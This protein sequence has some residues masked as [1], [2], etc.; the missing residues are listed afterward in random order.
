MDRLKQHSPLHFDYESSVV[1]ERR[2]IGYISTDFNNHA[3]AHLI[4]GLLARHDR[5]RYAVYGYSIGK[6]DN[7]NYRGHVERACDT[8]RD[9]QHQSIASIAEQIHQ[10][11]ID[12]LIDLNGYSAANRI[13]IFALRP[14]PVQMTY[15]GFPSTTGAAFFDYIITDSVVTPADQQAYFDERFLSL[16]HSYQVNSPRPASHDKPSRQASGLPE[17]GA[18]FCCFN[19]HYKIEPTIFDL[20]TRILKRV[21][22]SVLWLL[23]GPADTENNLRLEAERRGLDPARLIFAERLPVADHLA[24]YG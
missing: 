9:V 19:N 13:E 2:R 4:H 8:F 12:I 23:S 10:D 3:T 24:R 15:L 14:A 22:N 5:Y 1:K 11:G 20:W 17:H 18:V 6:N 16:P 21:S 7:S